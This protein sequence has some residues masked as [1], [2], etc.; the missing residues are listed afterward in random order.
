MWKARQNSQSV[1]SILCVGCLLYERRD[2]LTKKLRALEKSLPDY[3]L[4]WA[5]S[6]SPGKSRCR[7]TLFIVLDAHSM[8]A[9]TA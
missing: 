3:P 4:Y 2:G 7:C 6:R 1:Y 9:V 8:S 5:Y